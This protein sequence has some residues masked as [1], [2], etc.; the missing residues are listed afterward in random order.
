[1]ISSVVNSA[2]YTSPNQVAPCSWVSIFG[3][4]LANAQVL[5]SSV[6]LGGNLGGS[7]AVLAG[8]PLPLNFVADGQ[9]N[10]QI[11][12]GLSTDTQLDLQVVNGNTQSPTQPIVVSD[13]QPA[14]FTVNQ[15]GFGQGAI[16]GVAADGSEF[17]A[18]S[19]HPVHAGDVVVIYATGLGPVSPAVPE[20]QPAPSSPPALTTQTPQVTIG[21]LPAMVQF[22]GLTP[23]AVGLYQINVVVPANLPAGSVPVVVTQGTQSSQPGVTMAVH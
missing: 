8:T 12:C 19:S 11:P 20:G 22:S 15:Q 23:T 1:M 18:D 21:G 6:P 5:A 7:R 13:A 17:V 9:I 3:Q 4:S 14:L 2:S 16:F 10:A